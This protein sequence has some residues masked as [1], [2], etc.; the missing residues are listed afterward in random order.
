MNIS[1][2]DFLKYAGASAAALGLSRW[3]IEQATQAL[4][5]AAKPPVIWLSGSGCTGCSV[6]LLNAV[7][8]TID[9][10]LVNT[11]DLRYHPNLMAA[12]G[13]LAVSAA[14]STAS[15]GGYVLVVEGAIPTAS[16]GR[17]CYVWS[18]GGQEVTMSQAVTS[19][20]ASASAIVAVGTC[21]SFGESPPRIPAPP[22]GVSARTSASRL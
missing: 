6:S 21:A 5:A 3:Q 8:P 20:A 1:R 11:I 13:D 18:E 17:Y 14:R 4:S 16:Q 12:A 22:P 10:V 15:A 2:R 9:D 7:T 19:L